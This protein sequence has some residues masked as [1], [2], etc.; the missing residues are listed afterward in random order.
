MATSKNILGIGNQK[1][2]KELLE[3]LKDAITSHKEANSALKNKD[4]ALSVSVLEN[5][6]EIHKHAQHFIDDCLFELTKNYYGRKLRELVFFISIIRDIEQIAHCADHVVKFVLKN[7]ISSSSISR[8]DQMHKLL[9]NSLKELLNVFKASDLQKDD[10]KKI[11]K[12]DDLIDQKLNEI[13]T[14]VISS[15]KS[16]TGL[17]EI[18]ER[19][20][21]ANV[22]SIIEKAA[23]LVVNICSSLLY[24][25]SGKYYDF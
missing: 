21:V 20:F 1:I 15:L 16:K 25:E 3:V 6:W 2:K 14:E 8:I 4:N 5:T 18:K 13:R 17:E 24:I 19:L 22:V 9:L 12:S 11:A 23:D 10:I 7:D